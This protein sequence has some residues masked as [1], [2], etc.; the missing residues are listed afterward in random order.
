MNNSAAGTSANALQNIIKA[1][2]IPTAIPKTIAVLLKRNE[3]IAVMEVM[4][5]PTSVRIA[6]VNSRNVSIDIEK[7]QF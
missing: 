4:N 7:G 3:I 5:A 1:P 6:A 2:E